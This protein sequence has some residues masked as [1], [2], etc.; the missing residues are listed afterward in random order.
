[1]SVY[2]SGEGYSQNLSPISCSRILER[3]E[4]EDRHEICQALQ[5]A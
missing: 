1:M 2:E 4:M 3:V 5:R